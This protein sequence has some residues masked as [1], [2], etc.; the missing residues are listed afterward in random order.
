MKTLLLMIFLAVSA[1]QFGRGTAINKIKGT[2]SINPTI[3][4]ATTTSSQNFT[5]TG[6][7]V[8]DSLVLNLSAAGLTTGLLVTQC[9]VS[10]ADTIT[11]VFWNPTIVPIDEPAGNWTYQLVR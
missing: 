1:T 5:L 2:V 9:Y 7:V 3:I 8:G 6:A 11:I 4:S 10:A